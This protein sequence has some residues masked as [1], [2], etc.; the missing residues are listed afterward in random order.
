MKLRALSNLRLDFDLASMPIHDFLH[1]RQP[2]S[3]SAAFGRAE[4]SKNFIQMFLGNAATRI[5]NN[6]L[7]LVFIGLCTYRKGTSRCHG[8][9]SVFHQVNKDLS[10]LVLIH[11]TLEIA[12]LEVFFE[13][14]GGWE[15]DALNG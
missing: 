4:R 9:A 7:D 3:R 8:L 10:D 2:Q 14:N 15:L 6:D 1:H 5:P 13:C 12:Q 11:L